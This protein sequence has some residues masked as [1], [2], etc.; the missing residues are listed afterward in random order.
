[1]VQKCA[2]QLTCRP[3]PKEDNVK[4]S[5]EIREDK[6][7]LGSIEKWK[8]IDMI[9]LIIKILIGQ[10][11][12]WMLARGIPKHKIKQRA[13][14]IFGKYFSYFI[15]GWMTIII[16]PVSVALCG[17]FIGNLFSEEMIIICGISTIVGIFIGAIISL[18]MG[19]YCFD[20]QFIYIFGIKGLRRVSLDEIREVSKQVYPFL[21]TSFVFFLTKD[22]YFYFGPGS[23]VGGYSFVNKLF[24]KA[25]LEP[26]DTHPELLWK[27]E[28]MMI[29]S[30]ET[31]EFVKNLVKKRKRL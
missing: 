12:V 22:K 5:E 17:M 21:A 13:I 19:I 6:E 7:I 10:I 15:G 30:E 14:C 1:M 3:I 2:L 9:V 8:D 27:K 31:K 18:L 4:I 29:T 20:D 24:E 28:Y 23:N 25:S 11:V 16:L 26:I